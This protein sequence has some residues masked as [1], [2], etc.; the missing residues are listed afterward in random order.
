MSVILTVGNLV[1]GML[2]RLLIRNSRTLIIGT[3]I[4]MY[5]FSFATPSK[6]KK[7]H[8]ILRHFN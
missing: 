1:I 3:N 2:Q 8:P 4:H 7:K 6:L 5:Y